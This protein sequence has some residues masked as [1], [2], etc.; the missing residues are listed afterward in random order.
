MLLKSMEKRRIIN[1]VMNA[2]TFNKVLSQSKVQGEEYRRNYSIHCLHRRG[3]IPD[4][5]HHL[6]VVRCQVPRTRD[7]IERIEGYIL[8]MPRRHINFLVYI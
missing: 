4:S 2:L 3:K 5:V 7:T 8:V 6:T 1:S